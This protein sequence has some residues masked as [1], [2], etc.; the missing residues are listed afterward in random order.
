MGVWFYGRQDN[1][2]AYIFCYKFYENAFIFRIRIYENAYI[3]Y[4]NVFT[5]NENAYIELVQILHRLMKTLTFSCVANDE[6]AYICVAVDRTYI[7]M[8]VWK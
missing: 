3:G 7:S 4:E 8:G 1:E 2:N 6:N 5:N